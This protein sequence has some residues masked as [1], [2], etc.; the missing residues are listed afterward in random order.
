MKSA[1]FY[2][3]L[4]ISK[5]TNHLLKFYKYSNFSTSIINRK[6]FSLKLDDI[7]GKMYEVILK[8][9]EKNTGRYYKN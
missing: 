3:K 9:D 2:S 7:F 6:E 8:N 4:R 1:K 5:Q